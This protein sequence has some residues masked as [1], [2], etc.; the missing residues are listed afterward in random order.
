M[1]S[2]TKHPRSSFYS[3]RYTDAA[4]RRVCRSTKQSNYKKALAVAASWERAARMAKE[5]ELT[6]AASTKII[7][8]LM[9]HSI[10]E[11]LKR[12]TIAE[13]LNGYAD[14]A[15][16]SPATIKRYEPVVE[17]FLA[18][19]GEA[20]SG[21]NVASLTAAEIEA[22]H[23]AQVASGK[24]ASTA[25]YGLKLI[26]AA[27]ARTKRLG[28]LL[29]NPAESVRVFGHASEARQPF[30]DEEVAALLGAANKEWR[31]MILLAA[32][33]GLRLADAAGLTWS[34]VDLQTKTLSFRPSKTRKK[35]PRPLV[36]TIC[37]ELATAIE[38][39]PHG[40]GAAPLFPSLHGRKPGSHGGLSNEFSRLMAKAGIDRGKGEK[41]QGKG[42]QTRAKG[43]HSLRHT[44]ISRMANADVSADVRKAIAGHSTDDAHQRYT[45]LSL[46]TQ[47]Q[48][49]EKLP[50]FAPAV[51]KA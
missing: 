35:D 10:G 34:N 40:I 31:G 3:A 6:Q 8:E 14:T 36:L 46:D 11:S 37:P 43:F 21:A 24:S 33:A 9:E 30:T 47:R 25:D 29:H 7:S 15:L 41:K 23:R 17:S 16:H 49:V 2:I 32:W 38:E 1:A 20:R 44:M 48:A 22:W 4:G 12:F 50:A 18:H 39:L 45:H 19:L 42:R 5:R 27:L 28:L 13:A 51:P 26:S